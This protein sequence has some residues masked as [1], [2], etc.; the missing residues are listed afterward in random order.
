MIYVWP[1]GAVAD[2]PYEW[3]SDDYFT[4]SEDATVEEAE[5]VLRKH[6]S[7]LQYAQTLDTVLECL[8]LF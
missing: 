6:F 1:N 4:I 3:C 5:A 7:G 8:G 2:E